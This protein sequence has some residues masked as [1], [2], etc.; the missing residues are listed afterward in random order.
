MAMRG[1]IPITKGDQE[2]EAD[3][4]FTGL[5]VGDARQGRTRPE[6]DSRHIER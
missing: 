1:Q 5:H 3:H 2:T 6:E 4:Q